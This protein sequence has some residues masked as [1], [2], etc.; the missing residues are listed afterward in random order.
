VPRLYITITRS[1]HGSTP[2]EDFLHINEVSIVLLD[3]GQSFGFVPFEPIVQGLLPS[4][5]LVARQ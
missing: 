5:D 2:I 3:V 1:F 4:F